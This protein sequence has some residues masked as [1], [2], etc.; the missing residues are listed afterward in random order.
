MV[1]GR[2]HAGTGSETRIA[3]DERVA[4]LRDRGPR[5]LA[6][7]ELRPERDVDGIANVEWRE[8]GALVNQTGHGHARAGRDPEL[9]VA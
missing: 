4:H 7:R 3:S 8:R 2:R 5:S 9:H 1:A 6:R